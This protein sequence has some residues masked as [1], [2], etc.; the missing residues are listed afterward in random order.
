MEFIQI[1]KDRYLIKNSNSIIVSKEEML[2]LQKKDL[3]IKDIESSDC[4]SETTQKIE[5][6]NEELNDTI[7][8]ARKSNR[9][10]K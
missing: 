7:K 3:V 5:S 9:G 1:S 10:H 8:K 6:I 2:K 4:Q